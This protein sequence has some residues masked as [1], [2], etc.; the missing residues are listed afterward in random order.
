LAGGV[1]VHEVMNP[2][3]PPVYYPPRCFETVTPG[4]R[5]QWGRFIQTGPAYQAEVP[6]PRY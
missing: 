3:P 4:Y 5:D 6:C 1:V 2:P